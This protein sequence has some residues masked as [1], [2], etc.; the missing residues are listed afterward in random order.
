MYYGVF[1]SITKE[2]NYEFQKECVWVWTQNE[3]V[4]EDKGHKGCKYTWMKFKVNNIIK[5]SK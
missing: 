4:E 2:K 5:Q 1:T 3:Q